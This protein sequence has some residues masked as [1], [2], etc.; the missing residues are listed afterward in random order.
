MRR[1]HRS[2]AGGIAIN[3]RKGSRRH[4]LVGNVF[5]TS[6][7]CMSASGALVGYWKDQPSNILVGLF[8]FYLVATAWK[9]GRRRSKEVSAYDRSAFLFVLAVT[10]SFFTYAFRAA[11]ATPRD[12][13]GTIE[14]L[15]FGSV[16]LLALLGD[17]RMLI[18]GG[19]A[20]SARIARH[21]WRMCVPLFIAANAL[22]LARAKLF[23]IFLQTHHLLFLPTLATLVTMIF[24]LIRIRS[25]RALKNALS[26]RMPEIGMSPL[27]E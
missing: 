26:R 4:R 18:R 25:G 5:V 13:G 11:T 23:P 21:L 6:M 19:V 16:S 2:V 27:R 22:F 14:Y 10:A 12:G 20:G 15:V 1:V 8:T 7:L 3:L 17:V 24:W 9:A